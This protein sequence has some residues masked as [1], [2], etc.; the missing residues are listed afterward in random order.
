M[1]GR[2]SP[3][4]PGSIRPHD[5]DPVMEPLDVSWVG[6]TV[7]HV[8]VDDW[9]GRKG[10]VVRVRWVASSE[11]EARTTFRQWLADNPVARFTTNLEGERYSESGWSFRT[12]NIQ[13]WVI[14]P[15]LQ[16][17]TW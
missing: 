15:I 6:Y 3:K 9:V 10:S 2:K 13:S 5:L 17:P 1:R 7:F 14:L 8:V 16:R 12:G 4:N 11:E